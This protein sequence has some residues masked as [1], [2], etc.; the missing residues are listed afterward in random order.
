ME[1]ADSIDRI[2][3]TVETREINQIVGDVLASGDFDIKAEMHKA[4]PYTRRVSVNDIVPEEYQA[5][6]MAIDYTL[7]QCYWMIGDIAAELVNN[8]NLRRA[9]EL[10]KAVSMLDVF[11]A[12]G[13]FCHRSARSVRYYYEC[14]HFF[15]VGV[16]EKYDVPF[17]IYAEARWVDD[18]ECVL[19]LSSDNPQWSAERVRME[20]YS[21]K[22]EAVPVREGK[23]LDQA[24]LPVKDSGAEVPDDLYNNYPLPGAGEVWEGSGQ[25][26]FK[27]LLLSKLD[28]TVDDLRALLDKIPLPTEIRVRIGNVIMDIQD[29]GLEVRRVG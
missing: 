9:R 23:S 11:E 28:H 8:V 14:A 1:N 21:L 13:Y 29:I 6:L 7:T 27:S 24:E 3:D 2:L 25:G 16:R 10:G 12:V 15:P 4:L 18:W 22:G 5:K 19:R 20:Y 17:N 26:R